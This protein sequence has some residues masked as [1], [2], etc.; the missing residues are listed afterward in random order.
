MRNNKQQAN[1]FALAGLAAIAL[2]F[3]VFS[4]NY[5]MDVATMA[6]FY[7]VLALGLNVVVGYAGL[8]DLGY[9]A[10]FAVGAYTTG[11]LMTQYKLSFWVTFLLAGILAGLAGVIIG[12]PTLRLR[13]D[14][15]AIVT[16]G[17]GEIIRISAKNL[18][19]TGSASGI[20]GIP[21]PQIGGYT[22][23]TITDFYYAMLV[24]AIVTLFAV[25]RLGHSRIGR[26]W[27]YI[28]EDEDAA[29]AMGIDRVRLKLLAYAIGAVFGGFA[30]S[31]FAVKMSAIAPESFNFMQ[32]VMIL[33]AIV[34]GG[35]GRLPGVVLGAV[36]VILLPEAM[37]NFSDWRFLL[38]GVALVLMMLF[39]PQGLWPVRKDI[40]IEQPERG[41]SNVSA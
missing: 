6:L 17:F 35:L 24:L 5:W 34:L 4:N 33:L 15:L 11:I 22:L 32:S 7:I 37:R 13:S 16:L 25:Y 27:Q 19:I 1:R 9:S 30:G 14:Y 29:E 28:R 40:L 18:Q 36:L 8:L 12:A 3:P 10:F 23:S 39:R 21:R 2:L 20:F 38:F 26:A 41:G 31:L